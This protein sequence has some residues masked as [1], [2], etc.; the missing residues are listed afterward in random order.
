MSSIFSQKLSNSFKI[1]KTVLFARTLSQ[2]YWPA[3]SIVTS[4]K[5]KK[6]ITIIYNVGF[7]SIEAHE[8]ILCP[9]TII[10][11]NK[12]DITQKYER[13]S[14]YCRKLTLGNRYSKSKIAFSRYCKQ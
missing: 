12:Q 1:Y 14:L 10:F 13:K 5:P 8:L 2:V 4:S 9:P 7:P 11:K 6:L 3:Y